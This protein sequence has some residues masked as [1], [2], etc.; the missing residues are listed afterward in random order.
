MQPKNEPRPSGSGPAVWIAALILTALFL[1]GLQQIAVAPLETGEV[2]PPYSSLRTD[3][4]GAKALYE[5]LAELDSLQATRLYKQRTQLA[6]QSALLVLG[7]DPISWD[8]ITQKALTEYENLVAKGG[9]LV[10]AFLPVRA[11][12][13]SLEYPLLF[14]RWKLRFKYRPDDDAEESTSGVP[15][16]SALYFEPGEQWR[17]LQEEEDAPTI[18]ERSFG[19]GTIVLVAQSYPLSNEG[20]REAR[21]AQEIARLLGPVSKVTFDENHFGIEES[22]SVT[23]LMRKY[24]L[25]PAIGVLLLTALLFLWRNAS[26]LLPPR[27][28]KEQQ[29]VAGRDAQEGLVSLLERSL[30]EKDLLDTCYAEWSRTQPG[31][32]RAHILEAEIARRAG[33][34]PIEIYRAACT[35]LRSPAREKP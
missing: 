33:K 34:Q 7:V 18:I 6:P 25:E 32:R 31:N 19:A 2:Y 8:E 35:A 30:P 4:L 9:R 16:D 22:G 12:R 5:S 10:L 27:S 11:P 24:H 26:S 14:D 20:L 3:P 13:K 1:W 29:A 21:D 17:V 23:T 28:S 15:R